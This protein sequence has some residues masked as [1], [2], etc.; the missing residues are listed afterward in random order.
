MRRAHFVLIGGRFADAECAALEFDVVA[1]VLQID[2]AFEHV[3][4]VEGKFGNE[5]YASAMDARAA[6]ERSQSPTTTRR[7][8]LESFKEDGDIY[9][10]LVGIGL[11]LIGLI[12][13]FDYPK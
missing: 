11:I 9:D 10:L 8:I 2:E 13:C 1:V 6:V 7:R 3:F 5:T 4:A 12:I